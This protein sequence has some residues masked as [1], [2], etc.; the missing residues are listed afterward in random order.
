MVGSGGH[1]VARKPSELKGQWLPITEPL[2]A[3]M[4]NQEFIGHLLMVMAQG[5]IPAV[6]VAGQYGKQVIWRQIHDNDL[7]DQH[8]NK[9]KVGHPWVD[10]MFSSARDGC[11]VVPHP[12]ML[13]RKAV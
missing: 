9:Y 4:G 11:D 8:G 12:G 10:W 6:I 1:R 3:T 13:P 7:I 5:N 2:E